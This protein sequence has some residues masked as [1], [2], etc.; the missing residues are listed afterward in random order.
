MRNPYRKTVRKNTYGKKQRQKNTD[1]NN[2][3]NNKSKLF[4]DYFDLGDMAPKFTLPGIVNKDPAEI[5]LSDYRGKWLLLFF[6]G[7]DFTFV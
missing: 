7:S 5:S 6:Y 4:S 3:N 1:D 2:Y